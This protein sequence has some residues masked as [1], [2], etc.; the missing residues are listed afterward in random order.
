M[1]LSWSDNHGSRSRLPLHL[2][3]RWGAS[4]LQATAPTLFVVSGD[5][6]TRTN[7]ASQ[8]RK[9]TIRHRVFLSAGDFLNGYDLLW[10]GCLLLDLHPATNDG[11]D[12]L[13]RLSSRGNTLPV[14]CV[15]VSIDVATAVQAMR[16]GALTVLGV[17]ADDVQLADAVRRACAFDQ[18]Q[19]D[20]RARRGRLRQR[21]QFLTP[22][23]RKVAESIVTGKPGRVVAEELNV[24][25]AEVDRLWS[26]AC[27]TLEVGSAKDLSLLAAHMQTCIYAWET[28]RSFPGHTPLDA[29]DGTIS[30]AHADAAGDATGGDAH[31]RAESL[32]E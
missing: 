30:A 18:R 7:A 3:V 13:R 26:E 29:S 21:I 23:E 5:P 27:K 4:R 14:I 10:S 28:G 6:A 17:S 32:L 31:S 25:Q 15:G 19:R 16:L 1:A 20:D 9:L 22:R 11:L 8:A 24:S 12:F 2:G